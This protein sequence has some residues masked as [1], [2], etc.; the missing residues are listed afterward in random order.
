MFY[1]MTE[2]ER[3]RFR[4]I[5]QDFEYICRTLVDSLADLAVSLLEIVTLLML[6]L[7]LMTLKIIIISIRAIYKRIRKC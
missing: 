6:G 1:K 4:K 7:P 3:M 5:G 2:W